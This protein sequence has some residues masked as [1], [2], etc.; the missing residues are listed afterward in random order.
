MTTGSESAEYVVALMPTDG[1]TLNEV[2]YRVWHASERAHEVRKVF[3]ES[4]SRATDV[5]TVDVASDAVA[6][7]AF[8][9]G[10]FTITWD[11]AAP[12]LDDPYHIRCLFGETA[13]SIRAA[14][15]SLVYNVAW[16]DSGKINP[17][18]Q[19]PMAP[20][21]GAW[22]K[23]LNSNRLGGVSREHVSWIEE[24]QPFNGHDW[25][26]TLNYVSNRDKHRYLVE[27]VPTLRMK[28]DLEGARPHPSLAGRMLLPVT[29]HH[30][31]R[32]LQKDSGVQVNALEFINQALFGAVA[33]IN[34]FLVERGEAPLE[35]EIRES[36]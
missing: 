12:T 8:E 34:R 2:V 1:P 9:E 22:A 13:H 21:R 4:S 10:S 27:V 25:L 11:G 35:P 28:A 32:L 36:E 14:L 31:L 29:P 3:R 16:M 24:V 19:F 26:D 23:E 5:P 15:D 6:G 30:E 20:T 18:T 33:L 7:D 17:K